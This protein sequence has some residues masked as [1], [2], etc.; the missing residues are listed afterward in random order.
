MIL[1]RRHFLGT[2]SILAASALLPRVGRGADRAS[3]GRHLVLIE[4]AGG[5]DALN[6]VIPVRDE[7]Y[8]SNRPTLAIPPA[9]ALM[10]DD[11]TALHPA[12]ASIHSLYRR[13]QLAIVQGVGH[14]GPDRSHSGNRAIWHT[15][16]GGMPTPAARDLHLPKELGS[17]GVGMRVGR[18]MDAQH[19]HA[20]R[21]SS[22][23]EAQSTAPGVGMPPMV[24]AG[25]ECP[26][27]FQGGAARA[28]QLPAPSLASALV[29]FSDAIISRCSSHCFHASLSGF[30]THAHQAQAHAQLLSELSEAV[31]G[32]LAR[33]RSARAD[34]SVM[35]MIF[36]EFG[37]RL[38]ENG[39][40][41]TDHGTAGVAFFAGPAVR[42]GVYGKL[43]SLAELRDGDLVPT[44]NARDCCDSVRDWLVCAASAL[45]GGMACV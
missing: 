45:T 18:T 13:G 39:S 26:Q 34:G 22:R 38:R 1:S 3:T 19:A 44:T 21:A 23:G 6:T 11:R 33:L 30:D 5:N 28:A 27:M 10:L 24:Y 31:G 7:L 41:G 9:Q 42:G 14:I 17:A 16:L 25:E 35:V 2:S 40:A 32:F 15:A 36:S 37:R 4:L 43:P 29:N 12:M 8:F 20:R